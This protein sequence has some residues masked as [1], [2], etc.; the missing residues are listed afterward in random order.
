MVL[1]GMTWR[2]TKTASGALPLTNVAGYNT[3][4]QQVLAMKDASSAVVIVSH[5]IPKQESPEREIP[6]S[7]LL[8]AS[9]A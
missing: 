5:P 9:P 6:A 4:V 8:L 7:T 1:N 2:I 3:M